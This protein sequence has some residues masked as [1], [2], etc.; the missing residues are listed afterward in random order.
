MLFVNKMVV[1]HASLYLF[2]SM[3]GIAK[4]AKSTLIVITVLRKIELDCE[5]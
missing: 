5:P 4:R 2:E 1:L 3:W